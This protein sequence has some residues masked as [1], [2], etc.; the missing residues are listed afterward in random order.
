MKKV[1][2]FV[3]ITLLG[4]NITFAQFTFS[5]VNFGM[6]E[7][8]GKALWI[9]RKGLSSDESFRV[10]N[11]FSL[12]LSVDFQLSKKWSWRNGIKYSQL[13]FEHSI[14]NMLLEEDIINGTTSSMNGFVKKRDIGY[15]SEVFYQLNNAED[16][17][18]FSVFTGL[19][20]KKVL[21]IDSGRTWHGGAANDPVF[22]MQKSYDFKPY[23]INATIGFKI[24]F[25]FHEK[26]GIGLSPFL[27]YTLR[28]D[29]FIF[30]NFEEEH[31]IFP[32]ILLNISF[33]K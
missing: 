26:W 12:S 31:L 10:A 24:N 11:N 30:F 7:L 16:K 29:H 18:H 3:I 23:N 32:G 28:S 13:D 19:G 33:Y 20:L 9:K 1:T 22:D 14:E 6:G 25:K 2:T 4:I 21:L 8:I 17:V 27:E 5:N 15:F